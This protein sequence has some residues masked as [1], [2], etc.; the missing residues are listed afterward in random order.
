MAKTKNYFIYQIHPKD[1]SC[2]SC[3][4]NNNRI[5][6]EENL[7]LIPAHYHYGCSAKKLKD[8]KFNDSYIDVITYREFYDNNNELLPES[9]RRYY[10]RIY[11]QNANSWLVYSNDGLI[12]YTSDNGKNKCGQRKLDWRR[13]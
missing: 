5:F 9:R 11:S 12:F 3:L 10:M 1:T 13:I 7:P 4:K 6:E 2:K 8:L